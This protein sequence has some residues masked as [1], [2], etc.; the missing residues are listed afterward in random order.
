MSDPLATLEPRP[1]WR[2][3]LELSRIPRGSKNEAAAMRWVAE[4]GRS[5]GCAVEQDG[6]GNV[7]L[8]KRAATGCEGRAPVALQVHADMVC[9]KNEGTPHDFEKDGIAVVRDGEVIRARGTTLGADNGVG[10][11]AALAALADPDLRHGPLEVLVTVDEET[12]LTGANA[13]RPGWLSAKYLLNLD[14]E[15]EG[16]LTVGC[17]GGLDTVATRRVT[18]QPPVAGRSALRVKVSGLRGGHSGTDI[19]AGRGNSIRILGQVLSALARQRTL[20][21][22]SVR[23]GNK[24]NAIPREASAVL[25]VE[26]RDA[27]VLRAEVARLEEAWRAVLGAFD[28]GLAVTVEEGSA[29]AVLSAADARAVVGVLLAGPHGVEAMS[30]AIAGLVQTS[31][32]LGVLETREGAIEVTFLTRSSIDSSKEALAARITGVCE[33]A[34]FEVHH[35]GGYPGWKPDPGAPL[36]KLVDDVHE[37]LFGKRM[38]VRAIHAG[39]ECGL[40]GQ[41]YPGLQMVSFG[42]TMWDAHTPDE[43][44]SIASVQNFWRLL[45][46]VLERV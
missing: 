3:F 43:R 36:V 11:A 21:L 31:T 4:Q 19:A 17:A 2:Y 25:M 10:L 33:V 34:G 23:G 44:V 13:V 28:P 42:P 18:R 41:K 45:R 5:L 30:P 16:E 24:R 6:V 27:P 32:N 35:T 14:S 1:L 8:R 12:G 38:L 26:P 46:G 15:E 22:V 39:L 37:Q 29:G 40:I 9:E 20:E 7:L